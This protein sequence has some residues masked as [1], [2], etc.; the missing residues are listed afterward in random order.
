MHTKVDNKQAALF[1]LAAGLTHHHVCLESWG[2]SDLWVC[3]SLFPFWI[4]RL[5][6]NLMS[7][8]FYLNGRKSSKGFLY[9]VKKKNMLFKL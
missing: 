9:K 8:L 3:L 1:I 5:R 2:N 4:L 7:D 6:A